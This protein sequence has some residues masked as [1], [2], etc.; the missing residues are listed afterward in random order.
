ME[1][2]DAAIVA[3]VCVG[4]IDAFRGLVD[5]HGNSLFRLAYRMTGNEQDAKDVVQEAFVRA[6]RCLNGWEARA[7]F[8]VWLHRIA[9]N[10]CISL[11][12][13]RQRQIGAL[14][15]GTRLPAED[16]SSVPS[17]APTPDNVAFKTEVQQKM[18]SVLDDLSPQERAAFILRHF[19]NRSIAEI[20]SSLGLGTSA[21]KQSVFRA[22]QKMRLALEPILNPD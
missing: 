4:D 18:Q 8:S 22:V 15:L 6:Y 19:E 1:E 2:S 12:R 14:G 16:L 21:A 20:S 17:N 10:L 9:A 3:R 11:L 7:S 13:K 5:R